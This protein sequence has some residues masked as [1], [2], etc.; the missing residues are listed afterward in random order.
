MMSLDKI[1]WHVYYGTIIIYAGYWIYTRSSLPYYGSLHETPVKMLY[2]LW[3]GHFGLKKNIAVHGL[4]SP[5]P[6]FVFV[7]KLSD[8]VTCSSM[9]TSS[10]YIYT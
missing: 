3:K 4:I 5:M 10:V 1:T 8:K 6:D 2:V 7:S 9:M